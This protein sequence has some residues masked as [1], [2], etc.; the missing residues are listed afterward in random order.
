MKSIAQKILR[1]I[2]VLSALA[3][4]PRAL[5]QDANVEAGFED[6]VTVR[7]RGGSKLDPD[8]EVQGYTGFGTNFSAASYVTSG[9]G[10]V[11]IQGNLEV[12]ANLYAR[13][14]V[15]FPDGS[16]QAT[17]YSTNRVAM[18][19]SGECDTNRVDIL[20]SSAYL[21]ST[22]RVWQAAA[23]GQAVSVLVNGSSVT[24]FPFTATSATTPL[25]INLSAF[26]RLGILCTNASSTVLFAFEGRLR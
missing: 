5:A 18:L 26:D 13:S 10:Q 3:I 25:A 14:P 6:D 20:F 21:V 9:V 12:G 23:S 15:V 11:Y 17:A 1:G 2:C 7:G 8:L 16:A 24:T 19:A 22:V 4:G